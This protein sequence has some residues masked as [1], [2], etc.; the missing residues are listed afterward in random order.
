MLSF[1]ARKHLE[2]GLDCCVYFGRSLD[3]SGGIRPFRKRL[4]SACI[5]AQP[6]AAAADGACNVQRMQSVTVPA[7]AKGPLRALAL[8]L[9]DEHRFCMRMVE[10]VRFACANSEQKARDFIQ[11]NTANTQ[12]LLDAAGQDEQCMGK[13]EGAKALCTCDTAA[14]CFCG[15]LEQ[16]EPEQ[17]ELLAV[18]TDVVQL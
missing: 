11:A 9:D 13:W 5:M 16:L 6:R 7:A 3:G 2:H 15:C 10:L 1:G 12:G 8:G 18:M 17:I 14:T 4:C